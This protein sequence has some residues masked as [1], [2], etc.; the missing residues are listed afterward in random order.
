MNA[1]STA[2]RPASGEQPPAGPTVVGL[3]LLYADTIIDIQFGV[4]T[5][6]LIFGIENPNQPPVQAGVVV[7]PTGPLVAAARRIVDETGKKGFQAFFKQRTEAA[8][9]LMKDQ[10]EEGKKPR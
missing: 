5:T 2:R 8:M 4:F 7:V 9:Q 3:P 1:D 10:S 6:K